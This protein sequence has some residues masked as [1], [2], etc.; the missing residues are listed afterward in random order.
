[1]HFKWLDYSLKMKLFAIV[2]NLELFNKQLISRFERKV[3]K[4][5]EIGN[6]ARR[7]MQAMRIAQPISIALPNNNPI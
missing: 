6:T 7:K 4:L 1:M 2:A 3:E 5:V